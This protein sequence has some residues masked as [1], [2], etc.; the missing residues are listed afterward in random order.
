M[1]E[2]EDERNRKIVNALR[3][4]LA[5]A[6]E[7]LSPEIEPALHFSVGEPAEAIRKQSGDAQ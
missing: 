2:S 7:R 1:P 3:T 4:T 5:E 6:A